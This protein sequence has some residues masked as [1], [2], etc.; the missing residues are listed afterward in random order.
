MKRR[1]AAV[2]AALVFGAVPSTAG[3]ASGTRPSSPLASQALCPAIPAPGHVTCFARALTS[4]GVRLKPRF[5]AAAQPALATSPAGGYT[6]ADIAS[7][8]QLPP[9]GTHAPTIGIVDAFDDPNAEA[10]LAAYRTQ[11]GLPACTSASGCFTK[12]NQNGGAAPLPAPD[13]SWATEISLDLDAATATCPACRLVLIE[14]V[15]TQTSNLVTGVNQAVSQG[16]TVL[17]LS[18]GGSE[19]P[20]QTQF[21]PSFNHRGVAIFVAAGDSNYRPEYPATSPNVIAVGGTRLSPASNARGWSETVWGPGTATASD[22][23]GVGTGS[24]CSLYEPKPSWQTDAGC[25]HRTSTDVAADA[26]PATGLAAY[27]SYGLASGGSPWNIFG[28]TS[29]AAPLEAGITALAGGSGT[30][31]G[32]SM[33]YGAAPLNDVVSGTNSLSG[34]SPMYLCNGGVGND[35]PSGNGTPRG[36]PV[37]SYT[38]PPALTTASPQPAPQVGDPSLVAVRGTDGAM[39]VKRSGQGYVGYGGGLLAA[40]AVSALGNGNHLYVVVGTDHRLYQRTDFATYQ[41]AAANGYC[42]DSPGLYV[43]GASAAIACEGGDH[44]LWVN[45]GSVDGSGMF[46]ATSWQGYGGILASGPTLAQVQNELHFFVEGSDH[47]V[48]DRTSGSNFVSHGWACFGHQSVASSSGVSY[49]ACH[50]TDG[51]AWSAVNYGGGWSGARPLGGALVDG[52]GMAAYAGGATLYVEGTDRQVYSLLLDTAGGPRSG[53][54]AANGGQV[55]NGAAAT[56]Q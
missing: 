18:F 26:D 41:P 11:F 42:L 25:A 38:A 2:V 3:H 43:A 23:N 8:Y 5:I 12:R 49:F 51:Q 31:T 55:G 54:F 21:D 14:A 16:A 39:W 33:F 10:D 4:N 13:V 53:G 29:L 36:L 35:G 19:D 20:S 28:G 22:P 45:Y 50:G 56:V 1:L 27:D 46:H 34:C 15:D 17:S 6:P 47:R 37:A 32:A 9:S 24:G 44:Q 40:P 7:A 48:W 30:T 52:T